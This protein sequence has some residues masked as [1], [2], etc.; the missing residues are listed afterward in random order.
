MF[1][2]FTDRAHERIGPQ[3]EP[4]AQMPNRDLA[5]VRHEAIV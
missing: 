1:L 4:A 5:F 2:E 3:E